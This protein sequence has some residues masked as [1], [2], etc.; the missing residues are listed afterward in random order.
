MKTLKLTLEGEPDAVEAVARI[1]RLFLDIREE[2]KDQKLPLR[3]GQI[4]RALRVAAPVWIEPTN[5]Y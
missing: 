2:G 3:P 1:C 4:R 5:D